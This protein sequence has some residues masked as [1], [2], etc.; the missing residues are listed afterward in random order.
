MVLHLAGHS[1]K[2]RAIVLLEIARN[3]RA[4]EDAMI[5]AKD[6]ADEP[7]VADYR[8]ATVKEADLATGCWAR[9]RVDDVSLNRCHWPSAR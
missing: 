1:T 5:S 6:Q 2:G 4:H 7:L 3:I 9:Y 8:A